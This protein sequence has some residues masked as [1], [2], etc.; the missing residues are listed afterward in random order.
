MGEPKKPKIINNN[1]WRALD[2]KLVVTRAEKDSLNLECPHGVLR[3]GHLMSSSEFL[4][5]EGICALSPPS[6]PYSRFLRRKPFILCDASSLDKRRAPHKTILAWADC[7]LLA[8]CAS[9]ETNASLGILLGNQS[10]TRYPTHLWSETPIVPITIW[11]SELDNDAF[12]VLISRYQSHWDTH[13]RL[14]SNLWTIVM[15]NS[16]HPGQISWLKFWTSC[17]QT[18]FNTWNLDSPND[19]HLC[20]ALCSNCL[21]WAV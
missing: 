17:T 3:L 6:I 1:P 7:A 21:A 5:I 13:N 20:G 19:P 16:S 4:T 15:A 10:V 18:E 14:Q 8:Q 12:R 9:R 11:H 2:P